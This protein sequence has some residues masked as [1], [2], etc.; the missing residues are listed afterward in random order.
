LLKEVQKSYKLWKIQGEQDAMH[1]STG[2]DTKMEI[3]LI[4]SF[5]NDG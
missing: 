2:F 1:F 3:P 4:E 5:K